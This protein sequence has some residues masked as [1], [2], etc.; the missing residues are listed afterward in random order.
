MKYNSLKYS[1]GLLSLLSTTLWGCLKDDSFDNHQSESTAGNGN[2][3][4][5]SMAITATNNTNHLQLAFEK[6]DI[7]TTFN[8][9]PVTLAGQP[10]TEDINVTLIYDPALLGDYNAANGTTHEE[11]P[12]SLYT[13]L[14]P[15]DSANGY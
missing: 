12:L 2:Q 8:A 15:G 11:A 10:A 13:V 7:D 3:K 4:V 1:L 6:S 14:N 5:V 9:I